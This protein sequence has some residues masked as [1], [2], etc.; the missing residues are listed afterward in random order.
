MADDPPYRTEYAK[1]NRS[2]CKSCRETIVK[3]T[4]RMARMV[5]VMDKYLFT[6]L[7]NIFMTLGTQF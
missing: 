5:Q 7:K 6:G 4:L 2:S 3:D 1:S